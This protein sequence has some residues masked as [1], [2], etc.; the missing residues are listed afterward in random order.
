MSDDDVRV[1]AGW[2]PDPLGLPQLRWWDNHAWTEHTSDARQPV[3]AQEQQS[4]TK[5]AFADDEPTDELADDPAGLLDDLPSRREMRERERAALGPESDGDAELTTGSAAFAE[6]RLSLEA[7]TQDADRSEPPPAV[8]YALS[9]QLDDAP[10]SLPYD[11]D[12]RYDDLLGVPSTPRAS[13]AHSSSGASHYVPDAA[14]E[15]RPRPTRTTT[16][17]QTSSGPVWVLTLLPVYALL[18]GMLI[19]LSGAAGANPL[20]TLGLMVAVPYIAGVVLA[21]ADR[22]I[23]ISSGMDRPAHW[24]WSL[25]SA[26]VYLVARLIATVRETGTGFGPVLTYVVLGLFGLGAIVAVPGLAMVY[27]PATWSAEAEAS[28]ATDAAAIG[29]D[30]TV[31]CPDQVPMLVNQSFTCRAADDDGRV[32]DVQV[33]LQRANGWIDW[34]VDDWGVFTMG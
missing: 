29:A 9:G 8:K 10:T 14:E 26:P 13:A 3:M 19:L 5:L 18:V 12:E 27:S 31:D 25:L 23:L 1:P 6:P 7:P 11:L 33:S 20:V 17:V 4:A 28:I 22:R 21:Y 16:A 2:Y 30:L 34:R 15:T 32:F 24:L